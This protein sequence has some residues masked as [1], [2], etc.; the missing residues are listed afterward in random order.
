MYTRHNEKKSVVATRFIIKTLNNKINKHTTSVSK[1]V[2]I[3]KLD[4]YID[5]IS[6][7]K[8]VDVNHSIYIDFKKENNTEGPEF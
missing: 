6:K 8:P 7:T 2:Y 1:N 3:D 4:D 5:T